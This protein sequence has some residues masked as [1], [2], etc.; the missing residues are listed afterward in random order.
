LFGLSNDEAKSVATKLNELEVHNSICQGLS[1]DQFRRRL[2]QV[3]DLP[4]FELGP[5]S[6]D[7]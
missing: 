5:P 7:L 3:R 1:N 6:Q 2:T 4:F